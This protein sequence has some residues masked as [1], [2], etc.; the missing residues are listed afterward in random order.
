MDLRKRV[1]LFLDDTGAA[2]TA[3]C[4]RINISNTYY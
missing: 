3:F 2:V 4:N 1:K